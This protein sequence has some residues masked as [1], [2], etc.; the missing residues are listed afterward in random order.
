MKKLA[1]LSIATL[2]AGS[3]VF[4]QS[5]WYSHKMDVSVQGNGYADLTTLYYSDD[6]TAA[7]DALYDA[8]KFPS[9]PGQPTLYTEVYD[10]MQSLN[11]R[12]VDQLGQTIPLGIVPGADGVFTFA[13]DLASFPEGSLTFLE[14]KVSNEWTDLNT[15]PNYTF[16]M[17]VGDNPDRFLIHVTPGI[18]VS[19]TD[20]DCSSSSMISMDIPSYILNGQQVSWNYSISNDNGEVVSGSTTASADVTVGLDGAQN[21]TLQFLDYTVNASIDLSQAATPSINLPADLE[22]EAG[23]SFTIDADV[24]EG[25]IIEFYIDGQLVSSNG[26]SFTGSLEAGD[27]TVEVRAISAEGCES[28]ETMTI[29]VNEGV[30]SINDFAAGEV[31]IFSNGSNVEVR[32]SEAL[33]DA[34]IA[35][36]SMTGQMV[37]NETAAGSVHT[38]STKSLNNG[39]YIVVVS[40]N[41]GMM[42]QQVAIAK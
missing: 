21:V 28:S 11:G 39:I 8:Y 12:N 41:D 13:F 25:D 32:L 7:F 38:L 10:V 33:A 24:T 5:E 37:A 22:V 6:A 16:S 31:S 2:F 23:E 4:A 34:N 20:G 40:N 9:A 14:D 35:M 30:T 26:A 15:S 17:K 1:I 19:G 27:Y 3:T 42:S 29:K 36:Y 18:T